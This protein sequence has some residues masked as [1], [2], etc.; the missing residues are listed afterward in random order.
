VPPRRRLD[1]AAKQRWLAALLADALVEAVPAL[2]ERPAL[3]MPLTLSLFA[4]LNGAR[5]WL[6]ARGE[7]TPAA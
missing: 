7:L 4:M 6:D 3:A 2:A 1:L 5:H